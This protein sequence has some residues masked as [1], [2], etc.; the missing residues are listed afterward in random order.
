MKI[1]NQ[2]FH[3]LLKI[4]KHVSSKAEKRKFKFK[5]PNNLSVVRYTAMWQ[6]ARGSLYQNYTNEHEH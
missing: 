2:I 5:Y 4:I 3:R 1:E 6:N